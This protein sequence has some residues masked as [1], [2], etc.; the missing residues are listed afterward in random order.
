[1]GGSR[2]GIFSVPL[3]HSLP[4]NNLKPLGPVAS[5]CHQ[6]TDFT[7]KN[8]WKNFFLLEFTENLTEGSQQTLNI[9]QGQAHSAKQR[10]IVTAETSSLFFSCTNSTG[11]S[12]ARAQKSHRSITTKCNSSISRECSEVPD[13]SRQR[14]QEVASA[15]QSGRASWRGN[16]QVGGGGVEGT[17]CRQRQS[18]PMC[19]GYF[20]G[21][22]GQP[23]IVREESA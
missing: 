11:K 8:Y 17:G 3:L 1:M 14:E 21:G 15:V 2:L 9:F 13:P 16:I 12:G 19:L 22:G 10:D 18:T 20:L 5:L 7:F 4:P 23:I 6:C